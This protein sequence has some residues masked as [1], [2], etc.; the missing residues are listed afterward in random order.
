MEPREAD[1]MRLTRVDPITGKVKLFTAN[2][3]EGSSGI[4]RWM[5]CRLKLPLET[6]GPGGASSATGY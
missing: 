3:D 2:V 6:R 5:M 4:L 1:L